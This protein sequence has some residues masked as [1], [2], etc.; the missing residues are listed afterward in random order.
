MSVMASGEAS[1]A[2]A[3]SGR[4]IVVTGGRGYIGS[5][6]AVALCTCDCSVVLA[7]RS[8]A[9]AWLP[10]TGAA[11]RRAVTT[12]LSRRE[13]WEP[14]LHDADLVF[15]LAG[16]EY[17]GPE[18]DPLEG[19]RCNSLPVMQLLAACRN[20]HYRPHIVFASSANIFGRGAA[21]P[22]SEDAPD[23]PLT[24][25][26]ANKLI[27]ERELRLHAIEHGIASIAL[28]LT[29][30]YGPSGRPGVDARVALNRMVRDAARLGRIVLRPNR[31]CLRD[32]L[33]IDDAV[34]ALMFAGLH[35]TSLGSCRVVGTGIA[36]SFGELARVIGAAVRART[37]RA[38]EILEDAVTP[39]DAFE[40][41]N[42]VADATRF[43]RETGWSP[44]IGIER[45]IGH[46]LDAVLGQGQ[47]V[48]EAS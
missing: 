29:N 23:E 25:W 26:S 40:L 19:W 31:D 14:L 33:F 15:H 1:L 28:R 11:R 37:G 20:H 48:L 47:Q 44:R 34:D 43:R 45:G 10:A 6:L 4:R 35:A 39:C 3:Y 9:S 2:R 22:L 32:F 21:S 17:S 41:R 12:D 8:R 46:A 42:F 5:A 13:G 24:L 16:I 30:V 27:A 36:S 7:D 38:V 18:T